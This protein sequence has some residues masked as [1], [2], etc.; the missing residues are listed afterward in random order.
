MRIYISFFCEILDI[1]KHSI[2]MSKMT[3]VTGERSSKS[4]V[5]A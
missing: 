5:N 3:A 4:D 2:D 1:M